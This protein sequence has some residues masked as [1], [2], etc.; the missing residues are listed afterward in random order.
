MNCLTDDQW[1]SFFSNEGAVDEETLRGH[2][3]TCSRCRQALEQRNLVSSVVAAPVAFDEARFLS[4]LEARASVRR[5][6]AAAMAALAAAA[7]VIIGL[8]RQWRSSGTEFEARGS[9][10][11]HWH[12][13]V[14]AELRRVDAPTSALTEGQVLA[15]N[16]TLSVWYRN[17]EFSRP[18]FVLA[19]LVDASGE[20]HWVTPAY[21]AVGVEPQPSI[22]RA[23]NREA[24]WPES[25]ELEGPAT[26]A[27]V[28]VVIITEAP[29]SVLQLE[30]APRG[31]RADPTEQFPGA[32]IWRRRVVVSP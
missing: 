7:L 10:A 5:P 32:V 29:G 9:N 28:L 23:S 24:L 31:L 13:R 19:Y 26:G 16:S 3:E 11:G 15:A 21:R 4:G 6:P 18:L 20:L 1:T 14:S 12:T 25:V 8:G 27:G 2:A 17:L 22:L 30:A